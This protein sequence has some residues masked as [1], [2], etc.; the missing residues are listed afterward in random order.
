MVENDTETEN[1]E[2]ENNVCHED[3]PCNQSY[4]EKFTTSVH[5]EIN[6]RKAVEEQCNNIQEKDDTDIQ[7]VIEHLISSAEKNLCQDNKNHLLNSSLTYND[8]SE[9]HCDND[10]TLSVFSEHSYSQ[11]QNNGR[12]DSGFV[13]ISDMMEEEQQTEPNIE[14]LFENLDNIVGKNN[15]T[16]PFEEEYQRLL[17][18]L[19]ESQKD[20]INEKEGNIGRLNIKKLCIY[21]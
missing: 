11:L 9:R 16:L 4:S 8:I 17:N 12:N 18:L 14:T 6:S 7:F 15:D 5:S 13:D 3:F 10:D 1:L 19:D 2:D 21:F 20:M